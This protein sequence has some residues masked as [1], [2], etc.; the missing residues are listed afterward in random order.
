MPEPVERHEPDG[1]DY[2]WVMQVTF[3]LTIAIGA[4]IVAI[5]ST[6]A[7]LP[8]WGDRAQFSIGIGAVVWFVVALGVFM[9]EWQRTT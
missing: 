9:Y 4:P 8:T 3:V 5:A 2:G 6:Q 1:I 7:T